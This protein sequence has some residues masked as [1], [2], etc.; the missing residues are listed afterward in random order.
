M[1]TWTCH[2]TISPLLHP[3]HVMLLI[4]AGFGLVM[5]II[6]VF[7]IYSSAYRMSEP[8]SQRIKPPG[9]YI[10]LGT[11]LCPHRH[12]PLPGYH[13]DVLILQCVCSGDCT[14]IEINQG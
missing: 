2:I 11:E 6:Q 7:T 8:I 10:V 14:F 1:P 3:L 9:S 12:L 5:C 4:P 13:G